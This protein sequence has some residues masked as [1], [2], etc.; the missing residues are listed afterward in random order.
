MKILIANPPWVDND[1]HYGIRAG[2]RW[3]HLRNKQEGLEYYPF[4]FFMAYATS[5]VRE[6]GHEVDVMDAIAEGVSRQT[7][8]QRMADGKYDMIVL[9]T[10]SPSWH[11][12]RETVAHAKE[13]GAVV[14]VCGQHSTALPEEALTEHV[15]FAFSGEYDFTMREL[16]DRLEKG[17]NPQETG[18]L[19]YRNGSGEVVSNPSRPLIKHVDELPLPARESL[20]MQRYIDPFCRH[21]PNAQMISSRGCVY[22]CTFCLEPRVFYNKPNYRMRSPEKVVDEM[23]YLVR[24][25][26]LQEIYFDDA[27]FNINQK[28]VQ[29]ICEEIKRRNLKVYWSCMA[30]AKLSQETLEMMQ[31][32]GCCALKFGVESAVP[33]ILAAIPKPV[34]LDDVKRVTA[35]CRDLGI[36]THATY[37]FG[38]PGETKETIETTYDFAF[39][40]GTD[41]AQF[42]V[43][44]PYPGTKF[45]ADL[46]KGG[47][48]KTR[49]WSKY[50]GTE[51]VYEYPHLSS[52]D[53]LAAVKRA[54][55]KI[56]WKTILNPRRAWT[57][58][59]MVKN[60]KGWT[61]LF[62]TGWEKMNWLLFAPTTG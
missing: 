12:D 47:H 31:D 2:S 53:I 39:D 4:P 29:Q 15:D 26:Q 25:F 54:R 16:A 58:A 13:T 19:A 27:S 43:S 3:P 21:A 51:I 6:A 61:G 14:A 32:A 24:T 5:V 28:R 41:T 55:K 10:A 22:T 50:N 42:S 56:V 7:F 49:D 57:Y 37:T 48:L 38:L 34:D 9:E 17:D 59:M 62:R 44:I 30:D 52:A 23:E 35:I 33:E 18:G 45:F 8:A 36:E 40:L 20:P 1:T 11:V 46:D 60:Y